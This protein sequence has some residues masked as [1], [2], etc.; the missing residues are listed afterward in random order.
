MIVTTEAVVLKSMKYRE[1]SRIVTLYSRQ[2][3]KFALIAKGARDRKNRF[4]SALNLMSH[5]QAV[6]YRK[7]NRDLQLLSQCDVVDSF[8]HISEEMERLAAGMAVVELMDAVTHAEEENAPLFG[9]LIQTLHTIDTA[10]RNMVN[11]LYGFEVR[12]LDILGFRPNFFTCFHCGTPIS[13]ASVGRSGAE[14]N[15][16][17]GGILCSQCSSRG[18]GIETVS[19]GSVKM[20]QHLQ[21]AS[22]PA[23]ITR[24]TMSTQM[25]NEVAATMRRCLQ[26]HIEGFRPL[27]SEK[28]FSLLQ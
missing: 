25:R 3:G 16:S 8:R 6:V 21:E 28:L 12:L 10:P 20:L 11:A 5:V 14:L 7:E 15:V 4:G 13:E 17:Y 23:A 22:D 18:M 26:S 19:A 27:K 24:I 9:L 1:T 2:F